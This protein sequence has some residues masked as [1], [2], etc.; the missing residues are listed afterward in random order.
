[1]RYKIP[2]KEV[3]QKEEIYEKTNPNKTKWKSERNYQTNNERKFP[4]TE[5]RH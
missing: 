3:S 5:N 1:M 4:R 2:I